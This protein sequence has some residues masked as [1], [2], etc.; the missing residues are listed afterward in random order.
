MREAM[1]AL[2]A[3]ALAEADKKR[4]HRDDDYDQPRA[5]RPLRTTP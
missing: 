3:E 4:A 1:D 2:E 5:G